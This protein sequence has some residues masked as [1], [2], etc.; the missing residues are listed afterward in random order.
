MTIRTLN[1]LPTFDNP[2]DLKADRFMV[3]GFRKMALGVLIISLEELTWDVSEGRSANERAE[4]QKAKDEAGPWFDTDAFTAFATMAQL[5]ISN[6]TLRRRCLS[7]PLVVMGEL[8]AVRQSMEERRSSEE[9]RQAQ[10]AM[11]PANL[12]A[13]N[14]VF[15]DVLESLNESVRNVLQRARSNKVGT[16]KQGFLFD[17]VATQ[18]ER[19]AWANV[20]REP[21]RHRVAS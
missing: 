3:C 15:G 5:P 17:E 21:V 2:F 10:A 12:P 19:V 9:Q 1:G 6:E 11:A 16:V 4:M 8:R 13:N 20:A 18:E 7:E 14:W